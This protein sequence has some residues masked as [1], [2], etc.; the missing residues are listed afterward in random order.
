MKRSHGK[1]KNPIATS[2]VAFVKEIASVLIIVL[3][4]QVGL[5]QGYHVPTGSME[6][7]VMT[8]DVI[9]ADKVTLGPRTPDWIGIPFTGIGF[10]VPAL[11]LPGIRSVEQG[12]IVVVRTPMDAHVPYVKRVIATGGQTVE[13]RDKVV[14]VNGEPVPEYEGVVHQDNRIYPRNVR[15]AGFPPAIG[16]RDNWGPYTVPDEHLFLMGDN[17]DASFDSRYFGPVPEN[18]VIGRAR[19]V[20]FSWDST[21]GVSL[22][23]RPQWNR[24]GALLQ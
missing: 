20:Y 1:Q 18:Q 4:I 14:Y 12:D 17:R 3:F 21:P 16:N 8:G 9:F 10:P 23:S 13:I 15:M 11:K 19:L 24:I 6:T 5:V 22:F 2:T 7:T